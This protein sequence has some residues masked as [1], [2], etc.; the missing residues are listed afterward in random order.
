M[1]NKQ[2]NPKHIEFMK[3]FLKNVAPT[4]SASEKKVLNSLIKE[5]KKQKK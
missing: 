3:H 2:I 4:L 1:E 5:T